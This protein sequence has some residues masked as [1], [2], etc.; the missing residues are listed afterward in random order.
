MLNKKRQEDYIAGG[1][2]NVLLEFFG[3]VKHERGFV[4]SRQERLKL[5]R[6]QQTS[7]RKGLRLPVIHWKENS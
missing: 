2:R 3:R 6:E 4:F 1:I 5:I 7:T